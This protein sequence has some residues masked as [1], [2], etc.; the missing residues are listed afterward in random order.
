MPV[1]RIGLF[2]GTFDPPHIGHLILAGEA[3]FQFQLSRLLWVLTP[4]P[5]HKQDNSIAP[6]AH[7]LPM[8]QRMISHNPVFELSRVEIDRPGPHYTI[9]TVR[10]I[11]E[12]EPDAEL[13]LLIGGDSLWDLPTWRLSADLVTAVSKIGVMRRPGDFMDL[14]P[15]E[16]K[17]PGVTRKIRFLDALVQ[18]VSSRELRR[19]IAAG[20]MYR[21]YLAPEVYDY[22]ESSRLYR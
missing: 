18:P 20:E 2:G 21:Y 22:I 4:D 8:L 12:Q 19:R 1:N 6:L 3:V 13:Y 11:A 14:T 15:L 17:L 7:R 5:P 9:D 10:L 16:A